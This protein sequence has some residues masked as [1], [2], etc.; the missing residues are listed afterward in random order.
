MWVFIFLSLMNNIK[1]LWNVELK[2]VIVRRNVDV[3]E[4]VIDNVKFFEFLFN[5]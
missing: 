4:I 1:I 2:E 5:F 3:L